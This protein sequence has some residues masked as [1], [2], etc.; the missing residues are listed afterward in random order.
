LIRLGIRT[1]AQQ[2]LDKT[3][4]FAIRLGPVRLRAAMGNPVRSARGGEHVRA[5]AHVF[6]SNFLGNS[7][8]NFAK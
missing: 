6:S 5:V 3:L 8:V 7:W 4:G 1:L 2:R